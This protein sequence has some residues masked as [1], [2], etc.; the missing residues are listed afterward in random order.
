MKIIDRIKNWKSPNFL[1]KSLIF[2]LILFLLDFGIGNFLKYWY[3]N[4]YSGYLYRTTYAI[5]S[6]Q[7][8]IIIFG[9]ST[10]NHQYIP[11][12]FE[13]RLNIS[14]YNAGE[15]GNSIFFHYAIL[16]GILKRYVPKMVILAFDEKDFMK[17][18]KSYDRITSLLP[19]YD[20]HPEFRP[21]I[22]LKSQFEKYKL[23]SKIY[24]YNSLIFAI[25]AGNSEFNQHREL[26]NDYK[27]YVPLK[28]TWKE[29][30]LYDT[31]S[32]K[33]ELDYNLIKYFKAFTQACLDSKIKLYIFYS[34]KYLRFK[35]ED[36]S[37]SIA[38]N[39]ARQNDIPFYEFTNNPNF[40]DRRDLY[41]D[42]G[43]LNERGAKIYTQMVIDKIIQNEK[44]TKPTED[45]ILPL[46]KY[47][48][49]RK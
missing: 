38:K 37:I 33:Y 12:I 28:E 25:G 26:I 35:Y 7:A 3:F 10:A 20:S 34:P 36:Q 29:K 19:Y 30:L 15:D 42:R 6:A 49:I 45:S 48:S 23:L 5:D 32:S 44:Q 17:A 9:S 18:Q 13:K 46:N 8:G 14:C 4:Q 11:D 27:G 31:I 21:I 40:L 24:P 39:I 41:A 2:L 1:F 47:L 16:E 22:Q 43:H